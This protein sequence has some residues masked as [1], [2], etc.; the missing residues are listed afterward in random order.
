MMRNVFIMTRLVIVGISHM[1]VTVTV[2]VLALDKAIC[3][4]SLICSAKVNVLESGQ[5]RP[6]L[7]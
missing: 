5:E 3:Q 6:H 1:G 2:T 7:V 4:T